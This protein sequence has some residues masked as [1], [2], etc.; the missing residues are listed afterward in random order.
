LLLNNPPDLI[1]LSG[2]LWLTFKDKNSEERPLEKV[3]I[4]LFAF[5]PYQPV[6]LEIVVGGKRG[7][8]VKASG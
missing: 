5:R 6:H 2:Y 8:K 7:A 4:P 3:V 1:D